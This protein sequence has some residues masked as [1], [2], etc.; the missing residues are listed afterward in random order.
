ME[1]YK[2]ITSVYKIGGTSYGLQIGKIGSKYCIVLMKN[3]NILEYKISETLSKDVFVSWV[4][5]VV[6]FPNIN[7]YNIMKTVDILIKQVKEKEI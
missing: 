4:L 3:K 2:S 1:N 7:P 5:S 6:I